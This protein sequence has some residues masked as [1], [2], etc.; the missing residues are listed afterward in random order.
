MKKYKY[1]ALNFFHY[2]DVP[3][4]NNESER[5]NRKVLM[6]QIISESNTLYVLLE[7]PQ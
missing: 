3:L 2:P 6:F 5:A 4:D 7:K 1:C